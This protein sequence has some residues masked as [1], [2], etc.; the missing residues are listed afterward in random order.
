MTSSPGSSM[1]R[2]RARARISPVPPPLSNGIS[3]CNVHSSPGVALTSPV[4]RPPAFRSPDRPEACA[5]IVLLTTDKD[6]ARTRDALVNYGAC[7]GLADILLDYLEAHDA[8]VQESRAKDAAVAARDASKS[9]PPVAPGDPDPIDAAI[10]AELAARK[11]RDALRPIAI[12]ALQVVINVSRSKANRPV[13]AKAGCVP[14]VCAL[15]DPAVHPAEITSRAC[16]VLINCCTGE[17]AEATRVAVASSPAVAHLVATQ[18]QAGPRDPASHRAAHVLALIAD[19]PKARE[20][21]GET[22]GSFDALAALLEAGAPAQTAPGSKSAIEAPPPTFVKHAATTANKMCVD[23]VP[24]KVAFARAGGIA[25]LM[26]L[27]ARGPKDPLTEIVVHAVSTLAMDNDDCDQVIADT[28]VLPRLVDLVGNPECPHLHLPAITAVMHMARDSRDAKR[29]LAT[30]G[31]IPKMRDVVEIFETDS[32]ASTALVVPAISCLVNIAIDS[33]YWGQAELAEEGVLGPIKR[34][35]ETAAPSTQLSQVCAAFVHAFCKDNPDNGFAVREAGLL[36]VVAFHHLRGRGD[37]KNRQAK[38]AL[39]TLGVAVDQDET[40]REIV[41]SF[42]GEIILRECL[43]AGAGKNAKIPPPV[44]DEKR[45]AKEKA[46]L[47]EVEAIA[48]RSTCGEEF[49]NRARSAWEER[50]K[51]RA[52]EVFDAEAALEKK[53]V[54]QLAERER[55]L[56]EAEA[57]RVELR[58]AQARVGKAMGAVKKEVNEARAAKKE[59]EAAKRSLARKKGALDKDLA[60]AK[61]EMEALRERYASDAERFRAD[62]K[63]DEA[64]IASAK[65]PEARRDAEQ[66]LTLARAGLREAEK[67]AKPGGC[68]KMAALEK[69]AA[70]IERVFATDAVRRLEALVE[71][72]KRMWDKEQAEADEA[73]ATEAKAREAERAARASFER[74]RAEAEAAEAAVR[75]ARRA[76]QE[77]EK[78]M[79]EMTL[80]QR[81][82]FLEEEEEAAKKK[83]AEER[84]AAAAAAA[85]A[86]GLEMDPLEAESEEEDEYDDPFE[87]KCG[88]VVM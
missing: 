79:E 36:P 16:M 28:G 2:V 81:R 52:K 60:D 26:R 1:K 77:R 57:A 29:Q 48:A 51:R 86:A 49:C 87:K 30:A 41:A 59:W 17:D 75:A 15:L 37:K 4:P 40:S 84:A 61:T 24:N 74:E 69:R 55:E 63:R 62:V 32:P 72:K 34:A 58:L 22:A 27:I 14:P 45:L 39:V 42:C 6:D 56:A 73:L 47:R 25:P 54:E 64:A 21:F 23:H 9:P 76:A 3:R 33:E 68:P 20:A 70:E 10:D 35:F 85:A 31:V 83:R 82:L 53:L 13:V 71:E 67:R 19:Q 50:K 88:C 7:P 46:T 38:E 78:K 18:I 43:A 44:A 12:D 11:A 65:D 80:R 66:R 5:E 8:H